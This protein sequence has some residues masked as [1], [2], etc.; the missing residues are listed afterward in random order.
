VHDG[1]PVFAQFSA[2][3]GGWTAGG[4]PAYGPVR[5]DPW[6]AAS[7]DPYGSWTATINAAD[8]ERQYGFKHL[9]S[10]TVTSRDGSAAQ[11][12]G[13]VRSLRLDGT[14]PNGEPMSVTLAD[15]WALRLGLRSTF[16]KPRFT[17]PTITAPATIG[18]GKTV[19]VRG[20]ASPGAEVDVWFHKQGTV[21]YSK[22]RVLTAGADGSW[23]TSYVSDLDY[24]LYGVSQGVAGTKILV[25]AIGTTLVAPASVRK[26][27]PFHLSGNAAPRATV[28]VGLHRAGLV[29][30]ITAATVHADKWGRWH[31]TV[32]ATVKTR[33]VAT[34]KK[35]K[36]FS[37]LVLVH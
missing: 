1:V 9:A 22:R 29:G 23:A 5:R 17:A 12:G 15:Q 14:G 27:K 31:A 35:I 16:W 25:K 4:D 3:N 11:W 32:S 28:V 2:S 18:R 21:G 26:G 19:V 37:R 36:S 34:S 30:F 13:R 24:R 8:L 6:D 20:Q 33:Y 10:L 7:G